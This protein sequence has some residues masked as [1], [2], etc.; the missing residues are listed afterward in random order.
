MIIFC[1]SVVDCGTAAYV[2]G[3]DGLD[4]QLVVR[5]EDCGGKKEAG[6]C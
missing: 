1:N 3:T 6:G 2:D 5:Q 4:E